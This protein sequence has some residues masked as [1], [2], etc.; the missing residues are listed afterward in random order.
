VKDDYR[1]KLYENYAGS[2][3]NSSGQFDFTAADKLLPC[4]KFYLRGWLPESFSNEILDMGCGDGRLIY[5]L[6]RLGYSNV[7]G[8]D[9]SQSQLDLASQVSS[10]LDNQDVLEFLQQTD[11]MFDLIVAFDLIEHLEKIDLLEFLAA[12]RRVLKPG[13]RIV[14][15]TPNAASPFFGSVRYGDLTHELAVTPVLLGQLMAR[16]EFS[17]ITAREAPPVPYVYSLK[18]TLR[19]F[20]WM[21]IRGLFSLVDVVETGSRGSA[22]YTRVFLISGVK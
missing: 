17:G 8:V 15:Q 19:Y 20:A 7:S 18:S 10:A 9:I 1:K 22:I 12:C 13:G 21:V 2:F 16:A 6:Q 4:V 5:S 3:K 14:F 11:R